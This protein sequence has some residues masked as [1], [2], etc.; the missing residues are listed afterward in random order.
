[1]VVVVRVCCVE[2][3]SKGVE[4]RSISPPSPGCAL[5]LFFSSQFG[6]Y[7]CRGSSV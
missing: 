5:G 1:V 4:R 7:Q 3:V 2:R 6:E